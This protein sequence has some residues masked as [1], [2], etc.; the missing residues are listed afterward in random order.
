MAE[1]DSVLWSVFYQVINKTH[2]DNSRRLLYIGQPDGYE[3]PWEQVVL[4][5]RPWMNGSTWM[6]WWVGER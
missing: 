4:R 3:L 6:F 5:M 2:I 1:L